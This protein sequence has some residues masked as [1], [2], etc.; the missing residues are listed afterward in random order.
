MKMQQILKLEKKPICDIKGKRLL[1][2]KASLQQLDP[3]STLA[4]EAAF[5]S[6]PGPNMGIFRM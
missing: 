3:W 4:C 5:V 6:H 2:S 1:F